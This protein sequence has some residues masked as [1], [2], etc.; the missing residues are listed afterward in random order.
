MQ[1]YFLIM[2]EI[3]SRGNITD[4]F[5]IEYIIDG[6]DDGSD[7][8]VLYGPDTIK[9]FKVKLRHFEKMREKMAVK[10]AKDKERKKIARKDNQNQLKTPGKCYNCGELNHKSA[11]YKNKTY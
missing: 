6:I 5:L 10:I 8:A 7:K 2:K 1:Q 3:A 11:D 4:N 9:D